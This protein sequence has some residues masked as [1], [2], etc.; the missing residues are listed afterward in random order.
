MILIIGLRLRNLFPDWSELV[1]P[2]HFARSRW[3][4]PVLS[5]DETG[6]LGTERKG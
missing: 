3:C 2:L 6:A 1:A 4:L 5:S